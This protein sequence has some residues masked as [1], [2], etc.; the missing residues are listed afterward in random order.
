MAGTWRRGVLH[1]SM[2]GR[3]LYAI[4][5]GWGPGQIVREGVGTSQHRVRGD[6]SARPSR[7]QGRGIFSLLAKGQARQEKKGGIGSGLLGVLRCTSR[8]GLCIIYRMAVPAGPSS[9]EEENAMASSGVR[10][11][12]SLEASRGGEVVVC[13]VRIGVTGGHRAPPDA[14]YKTPSVW[15]GWENQICFAQHR[16]RPSRALECVGPP[17]RMGEGRSRASPLSPALRVVGGEMLA[18]GRA[19]R[20]E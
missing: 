14:L 8:A 1:A 18:D 10:I 7:S 16:R 6:V 4:S 3:V 11:D 19:T 9:P 20:P 17:G 13:A 15:R 5:H 12:R 2:S